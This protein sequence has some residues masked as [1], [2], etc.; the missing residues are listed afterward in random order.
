MRIELCEDNGSLSAEGK[1]TLVILV[2]TKDDGKQIRVPYQANKKISDLYV[3]ARKLAINKDIE[4]IEQFVSQQKEHSSQVIL[5]SSN[6]KEIQRE[7][8]VTCIRQEKDIDGNVNDE[9]EIGK[10]YRVI[11]II[12]K[13][14]KILYYEVLDDAK[15]DRIRVPILPSEV[16]LTKKFVR[17]NPPRKEVF[18][19]TKKCT[20]G[21]IVV[22]TLNEN[23]YEGTCE[24]CRENHSQVR[25]K[26]NV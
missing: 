5:D 22:L 6:N 17:T 11:D 3:D 23:I 19:I 15:G 25:G 20:C 26:V 8:I 2:I 13:A 1:P 14:G 21:E 18:E 12:K 4:S 10:Q 24:V 16:E 7:D 9:I